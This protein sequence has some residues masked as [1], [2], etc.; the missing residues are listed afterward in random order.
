MKKFIFLFVLFS[1]SA[2]LIFEWHVPLI[3]APKPKKSEADLLKTANK[4]RYLLFMKDI[5]SIK[6]V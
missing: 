6:N 3:S 5:N 2:A 4:T 1:L